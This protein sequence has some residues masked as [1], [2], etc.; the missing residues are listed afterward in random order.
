M[1]VGPENVPLLAQKQTE[2]TSRWRTKAADD[3]GMDERIGK[4]PPHLAARPDRGTVELHKAKHDAGSKCYQ[5]RSENRSRHVDPD[6]HRGHIDRIAT[7]PRNRPIIIGRGDP[8]HISINAADSSCASET[9]DG[10]ISLFGH[11]YFLRY[12]SVCTVAL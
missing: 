2:G 1:R 11:S 7:H 4:Q 9:R 5:N 6:E 3:G 8:E 12:S 10:V